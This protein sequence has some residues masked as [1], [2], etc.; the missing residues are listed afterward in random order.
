LNPIAQRFG[1][2]SKKVALYAGNLGQAHS[3]LEI[4]A[5]AKWFDDR[6]RT[7]WIFV[8]AVRKENEPRLRSQTKSLSNV[9]LMNYVAESEVSALLCAA[10]VHF[11]SIRPG[12]EGV[13]VPSKIYSSLRTRAPILYI[14][15]A[16]TDTAQEILRLDRGVI[17]RPGAL[18]SEV[19]HTLD[20]LSHSNW[21]RQPYSDPT[22]LW[23]LVD[24]LTGD[25]ASRRA[26]ANPLPGTASK[27]A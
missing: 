14:G 20:D 15:P 7:D 8:F 19:A 6:G 25:V 3:F 27:D 18:G 21:L 9:Q 5:A 26:K 17:L 24:F 10:T 1:W 2:A 22:G 13:I 16:G 12:W 4:L 11:V 23:R